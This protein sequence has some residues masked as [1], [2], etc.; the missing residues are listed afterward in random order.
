MK[1]ERKDD[2]RELKRRTVAFKATDVKDTG[3]FE[4]YAS[5]FGNTDSYGDVVAPGAFKESIALLKKSGDPLPVLWQH[6]SSEP[7]GGS[8]YLE[9]DDHG[10]KTRGFLLID[11]IPQAKSA[12]TLMRR[13]VVKGLSIGY[14]TRDSSYDEKT[15]IRTLKQLD[16]VEY[17]VV[18]FPANDLATVDSVKARDQLF[19]GGAL[20]SL[21]DFEAFLRE[22]GASK[23]VAAA[24]AGKG[25]RAMLQRSESGADPG[26]VLSLLSSFKLTKE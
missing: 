1:I 20:P 26:E 3:E 11:E 14:Y 5:V 18:T 9:E 24:I 12:H 16:L 4:G 21:K 10:L 19:A 22:A 2:S 7:I 13:R 8:D 25:L 6:R 15:G 17:S 23:T